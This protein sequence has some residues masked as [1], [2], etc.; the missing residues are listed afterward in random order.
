MAM[1]L[2]DNNFSTDNVHVKALVYHR[3][4]VFPSSRRVDVTL[5]T[6]TLQPYRYTWSLTASL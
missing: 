4:F 3:Q 2:L 5:R 6:V 1:G